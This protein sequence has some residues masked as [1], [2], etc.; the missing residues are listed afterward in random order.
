M[1][2]IDKNKKLT[3]KKIVLMGLISISIGIFFSVFFFHGQSFNDLKSMLFNIGYSLSLG[4]GLFATGFVLNLF[5]GRIIKWV[6]YPIRSLIISLIIMTLY[7]SIIIALVNWIWY[8]LIFNHTWKQLFEGGKFFIIMQFIIYCIIALFSFARTFFKEWRQSLLSE[9]KLKE[10]AILLQYKVLSN[11]VNPHFL[12]NA[13]NVLNSLISIDPDR[14]QNFVSKLSSF[15]RDLLNF[16]DKDIILLDEEISFVENYIQ[17]QQE[18]FGDNIIYSNS[19]TDTK[20]FL[21]IPMTLQ[22]LVEN[23][24]KHNQITKNRKLNIEIYSENNYIIVR[25]TYQPYANPKDGER[26][27]LQSLRERYQFLTDKNVIINQNNNYFTVQ[28]PLLEKN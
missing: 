23:A 3:L 27:G 10:E 12:F 17:L 5:N 19:L 6:K 22:M 21:V 14:A 4:L 11:Q 13:L 8:I 9:Q 25:N 20:H 1:A 18:R 7:S 28:I 24:I 2:F 16:K 15:Y 26:F